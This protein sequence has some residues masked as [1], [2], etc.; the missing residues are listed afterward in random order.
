MQTEAWLTHVIPAVIIVLTNVFGGDHGTRRYEIT[1]AC[2]GWTA[3]V[4]LTLALFTGHRFAIDLALF[5][6]IA[7]LSRDYERILRRLFKR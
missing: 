1:T 4:S 3:A 2:F 5:S 6:L 7:A